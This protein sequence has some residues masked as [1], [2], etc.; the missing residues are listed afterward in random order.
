MRILILDDELARHYEFKK[1]LIGHLLTHVSTAAEAITALK[2]IDFEWA[3]LDHDLGGRTMVASG[4]GT[5]WEVAKWIADNPDRKPKNVV[6]HSFNGPG[7]KNMMAALPD[8]VECPG[9]WTMIKSGEVWS[10]IK[11]EQIPTV[12]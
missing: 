4:A 12:G 7:R 5:G 1:R 10:G 2:E 6:I 8:A 11:V 3:F 9:A